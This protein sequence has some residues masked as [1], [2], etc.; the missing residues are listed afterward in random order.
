MRIVDRTFIGS[1]VE[2]DGNEFERC[3]FIQSKLVFSATASVSFESCVFDR[4]E[5]VFD[6]PAETM[7]F[8]LSALYR[9]LGPEGERLVEAIFESIRSGTV[10][11]K[12]TKPPFVAVP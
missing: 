2:L 10:G 5:W 9:G 6:G 12:I 11:D 3:T 1:F 7:L 8:F 4:C